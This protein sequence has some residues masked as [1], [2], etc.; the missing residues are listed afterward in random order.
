MRTILN[1]FS[2]PLLSITSSLYLQ[3]GL[4]QILTQGD[5]LILALL[6]NLSDQGVFALASN[7]GG[8]IARMLFQPIEESS[9]N[10][11]AKL[12]ATDTRGRA[13]T[14]GTKAAAAYLTDVLRFYGILSI[15][16][17]SLG[18]TG[19]PLAIRLLMGSRWSSAEVTKLLSTYCYYIPFLA[20]NGITE[21]FVSSV[22]TEAELR[23]QAIWMGAFSFG[24]AGAAFTFLRTLQMGAQGLV[25]ANI[26]NMTMRTAWSLWFI[27]SYFKRN[28]SPLSFMAVLPSPGSV[29]VG[30]F[31][32][33]VLPRYAHDLMKTV[34]IAGIASMLM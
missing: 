24:F 15:V 28:G 31:I 25:W 18:P 29:L 34:G 9:R 2:I 7:Y 13:N 17:A 4:K 20:V 32:A 5:S 26:A 30:A 6:S 27:E 3:S 1:R 14:A 22:A 19:L 33:A 10:A 23:R 11:F 8:L 12:V 21:A 16:V